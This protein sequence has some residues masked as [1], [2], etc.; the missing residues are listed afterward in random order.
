EGKIRPFRPQ[1]DDQDSLHYFRRLD[2][3][4][5]DIA[6]TLKKMKEK[7]QGERQCVY[8]AATTEDVDSEANDLRRELQAYRYTVLPFGDRQYRFKDFQERVRHDLNRSTLCIHVL[9]S[10]YGSIPENEPKRSNAWIE[11]DL[12]AEKAVGQTF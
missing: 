10:G 8:L 6:E 3:L 2:D 5:L 12:A 11:N 1:L 4:A 7:S 9:G